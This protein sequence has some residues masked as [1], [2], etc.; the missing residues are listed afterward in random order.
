MLLCL[1]L[2]GF[3]DERWTSFQSGPFEVLTDA[4]AKA[5]RETLVR[6]EQLRYAL[7]QIVGD[8]NQDVR[9]ACGSFRQLGALKCRC[10]CQRNR[11]S[12][13]CSV[14]VGKTL[15]RVVEAE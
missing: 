4:G 14:H 5:G 12:E 2:A 9:F 6:F 10:P 11:A 8:D 7:G 13:Q 3:A 15:I 1:P